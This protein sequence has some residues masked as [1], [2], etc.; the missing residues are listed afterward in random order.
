MTRN[1]DKLNTPEISNL[2]GVR[3]RVRLYSLDQRPGCSALFAQL[4]PHK[5]SVRALRELT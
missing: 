4:N 5:C 3:T 1:I 2:F